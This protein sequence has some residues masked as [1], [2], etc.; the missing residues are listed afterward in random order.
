MCIS[1]GSGSA[2]NFKSKLRM[3]T[4]SPILAHA[5]CRGDLEMSMVNPSGFLTQAYRG[6]GLF[7]QPL[8]VRVL[9]N[10]PSWDRYVHVIHPRTGLKSLAELKAKKYPLRLSIREDATHSTRVLLDQ[11]LALY[12]FTLTE[13]ESWGG[14]LQLN[15]GPGDERRMNALRSGTIDAIIDEGL[16]LWFDEALAAGMEPITLD[17]EARSAGLAARRHSQRPLPSSQIR[18]RVHRLQRLASLH[19]RIAPR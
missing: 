7:P 18:L 12:G 11:T 5:V 14:S 15:G 8:P 17:D 3:S 9:A 19:P 4:G 13:L 1:V 16:V 2:E 6:T 10:Y